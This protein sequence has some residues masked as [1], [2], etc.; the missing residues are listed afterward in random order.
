ML[1]TYERL[2]V[3]VYASDLA[4]I[5]AAR[6]KLMPIARRGRQYRAERHRFYRAMLRRHTDARQLVQTFRL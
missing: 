1:G 2:G 3:H 6:L 4:V 5:R